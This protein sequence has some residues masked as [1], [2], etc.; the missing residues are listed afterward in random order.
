M[1]MKKKTLIYCI[2]FM[3]ACLACNA[4]TTISLQ[5]LNGTTWDMVHPEASET[6]TK[7]TFTTTTIHETVYFKIIDKLM[8][9]EFKYYLDDKIP[10]DFDFSK[11]GKKDSGT[12]IIE[13]ND[14]DGS[15]M[16]YK[17]VNVT[18]DTLT[19]YWKPEPNTVIGGNEGMTFIYK[20]IK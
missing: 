18:N 14:S 12:Y 1:D 11:V 13:Y 19:L 5:Q 15:F 10:D 4:Q 7:R 17:V 8:S 16:W 6:P 2:L 3:V 9:G 20:R